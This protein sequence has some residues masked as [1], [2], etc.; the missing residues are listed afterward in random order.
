V[1]RG[2]LYGSLGVLTTSTPTCG[3]RNFSTSL[4]GRF[5]L[6]LPAFHV[7]DTGPGAVRVGK[8][9][10]VGALAA[11]RS[12]RPNRQLTFEH[13]KA[14]CGHDHLAYPQ[15]IHVDGANT[16]NLCPIHNAANVTEPP[17]VQE[18]D[19]VCYARVSVRN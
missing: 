6:E 3:S 11:D 4:S 14:S 7:I 16:V 2:G 19:K 15:M 12:T 5:G 10:M 8:W 17:A 9:R 18:I 13:T 1:A